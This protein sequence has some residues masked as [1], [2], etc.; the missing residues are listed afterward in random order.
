M[1]HGRPNVYPIIPEQYQVND[2]ALHEYDRQREIDECE[3][4]IQ[5]AQL[6]KQQ[7]LGL[8]SSSQSPP[9]PMIEM[10]PSAGR[11][12]ELPSGSAQ[13]G[14]RQFPPYQVPA[15]NMRSVPQAAYPSTVQPY[16]H[17]AA[18]PERQVWSVD[19]QYY[20]NQHAGIANGAYADP[21]RSQMTHIH[22]GYQGVGAQQQAVQM[23]PAAPAYST[24]HASTPPLPAS[25]S[26][27][28]T[29][30]QQPAHR[31]HPSAP[32]QPHASGF[33][34]AAA[35][36]MRL[37]Q[38]NLVPY[39]PYHHF[40]LSGPVVTASTS[41]GSC[42]AGK[43]SSNATKQSAVASNFAAPSLPQPSA[44]RVSA[45]AQ[46]PTPP[47][48][49]ALKSSSAAEQVGS[50]HRKNLTSPQSSAVPSSAVD[51]V[52]N[53]MAK[54]NNW[55][56]TAPP[57]S[58][59]EISESKQWRVYKDN[60]SMV[61][62]IVGTKNGSE[63][64][65]TDKFFHELLAK[66][67][68]MDQYGPQVQQTRP[69]Q[70]FLQT[71]QVPSAPQ[72]AQVPVAV[73]A[74][75]EPVSANRPV[76]AP[77]PT[78]TSTGLPVRHQVPAPA[79]NTIPTAPAV[80]PP[81]PMK[82]VQK[83]HVGNN[84]R[85]PRDANLKH[86][87]RDI[88]LALKRPAERDERPAKRQALESMV[89]AQEGAGGLD[90]AVPVMVPVERPP[91]VPTVSTTT[92]VP[93]PAISSAPVGETPQLEAVA[94]VPAVAI[95]TAHPT[96]QTAAAAV[97]AAHAASAQTQLPSS[98]K[99]SAAIP[100]TATRLVSG[101]AFTAVGGPLPLPPSRNPVS[102]STAAGPLT[103]ISTTVTPQQATDNQ[104]TAIVQPATSQTTVPA[105]SSLS[106][107]SGTPSRPFL[108]G[109][110]QT[111]PPITGPAPSFAVGTTPPSPAPSYKHFHSGAMPYH[112][113]STMS[114]QPVLQTSQAAFSLSSAPLAS[115]KPPKV[116]LSTVKKYPL[117]TP[118]SSKKRVPSTLTLSSTSTPKVASLVNAIESRASGKALPMRTNPANS[119]SA[120]SVASTSRVMPLQAASSAVIDLTSPEPGASTSE[121]SSSKR[122]AALRKEPLFLPSPSP[123]PRLSPR[124]DSISSIEEIE[125]L[126]LPPGAT[127]ARHQK[128]RTRRKIP[129][130]LVP[131][132]PRLPHRVEGIRTKESGTSH[133]VGVGFGGPVAVRVVI[134]S[135]SRRDKHLEKHAMSPLHCAYKDCNE[136]YRTG[137]Q[138]LKHFKAKHGKDTLRP[139]AK[140]ALPTLK[141][142]SALPGRLPAFL[143]VT[144][145]VKSWPI[146]EQRHA[147]LGPW[148]LRNIVESDQEKPRQRTR[149]TARS[150]GAPAIEPS[151]EYEFLTARTTRYSSLLSQPVDMRLEDLDSARISKMID[152]GLTFWPGKQEGGSGMEK[153]QQP[154]SPTRPP[155]SGEGEGDGKPSYESEAVHHAGFSSDEDAVENMLTELSFVDR[156]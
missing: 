77:L 142:V 19:Q 21:S 91:V 41:V 137:G 37:G 114:A 25:V 65:S 138:L 85:S 69:Q 39:Q 149:K 67:R 87:A 27:G 68:L 10:G 26:A 48:A 13:T 3:A 150:A 109:S 22:N 95:V 42:L 152:D 90:A 148:V 38:A 98:T 9:N 36:T 115:K 59:S 55:A 134:S 33:T 89:L 6:R 44:T 40:Q 30:N 14:Q 155:G 105:P 127:K 23:P 51:Y 128:N 147:L 111:Q 99:V 132:P 24:Q 118:S 141:P 107:A 45:Q 5:Q 70:T 32:Q 93:A 112:M 58:L 16:Y 146:S 60:Q 81:P 1:S 73:K 49:S 63:V 7:L 124:R 106:T 18:Y 120:K 29:V 57:N 125:S 104:P 117:S 82:E 113:L 145:P 96:S 100:N 133:S 88:L 76:H 54:V 97:N 15:P 8:A 101:Q 12:Q 75:T 154:L 52:L 64:H 28:G 80:R 31:I 94:S 110:F 35:S 121:A 2:E 43:G 151:N 11:I 78:S 139:S 103:S 62:I 108:S 102:A 140:P 86:L 46:I 83:T 84:W 74:S 143:I 136:S 20:G 72:P 122:P 66:A 61:R 135:W 71:P 123:E 34:Q 116:D 79:V 156:A 17:A 50:A 47:L 144:G 53:S 153:P 130:I 119:S 129:Y 4:L 126:A 92:T 131:P 56:K